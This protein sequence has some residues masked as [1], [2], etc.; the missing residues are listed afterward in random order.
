M[1][2]HKAASSAGVIDMCEL[3]EQLLR[4]YGGGRDGHRAAAWHLAAVGAHLCAKVAASAATPRRTLS[5]S[6]HASSRRRVRAS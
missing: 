3:G 2:I 1:M 5:L 4:Q 6:S